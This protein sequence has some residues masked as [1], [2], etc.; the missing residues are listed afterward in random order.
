MYGKYPFPVRSLNIEQFALSTTPDHETHAYAATYLERQQHP[1]E[2]PEEAF[3]WDKILQEEPFEGQHWEGAYGLPAGATMEGWETLDAYNLSESDLS[4]LGDLELP[5]RSRGGQK[6]NLSPP[7]LCH[8]GSESSDDDRSEDF[9]ARIVME[10]VKSLQYWR[11][12]APISEHVG[13]TFDLGD[14][15]SLGTYSHISN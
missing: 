9:D 13:P 15:S 7:L 14:P 3:T 2:R 6:R 4:D 10:E 11:A 1:N 5:L 8:D 12:S